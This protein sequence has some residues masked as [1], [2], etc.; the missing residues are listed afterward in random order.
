MLPSA[1]FSLT[2]L[3][4]LMGQVTQ[5]TWAATVAVPLAVAP[6]APAAVPLPPVVIDPAAP[7]PNVIS[8]VVRDA[9]APTTLA[10]DAPPAP[11]EPTTAPLPPATA[12]ADG[13]AQSPA[14]AMA[15]GAAQPPA[16]PTSQVADLVRSQPQPAAP[17]GAVIVQAVSPTITSK[18]IV[19]APDEPSQNPVVLV[20]SSTA[21]PAQIITPANAAGTTTPVIVQTPNPNQQPVTVSSDVPL[22]TTPTAPVPL[23]DAAGA[24]LTAPDTPTAAE[25]P[26]A[27]PEAPARVLIPRYAPVKPAAKITG[28]ARGKKSTP[29]PPAPAVAPAEASTG[30]GE[31]IDVTDI[32]QR[33]S[34][35]LAVAGH[36]PPRLPDRKAR[37]Q[38][39]QD[40]TALV[41]E[42]DPHAVLPN[43]SSE[44]LLRAVKANQIARN[45]DTGNDSALKAGVYMRRLIALAPADPE[46]NYWYGTLLA[47]GGGMA[48]GMPYLNKAI[49]AGYNDAYLPLAQAYLSLDKKTDA[50]NTLKTYR[51]VPNVDA[52]RTDDL[53]ARVEAGATSIW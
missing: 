6:A 9:Q 33:L 44:V 8:P 49:K 28:K 11:A 12:T 29:T 25:A 36:Y 45:L 35:L 21:Q 51:N 13:A 43:A 46:V 32:D 48:E 40:A 14:S 23:V 1:R 5:V 53:I 26:L 19:I 7:A 39:E 41:N 38:A 37:M 24:A 3:V 47:E 18:P 17:A 15:D 20:P 2:L 27:Q 4:A 22:R 52:A 10:V 34:A 50:L 30:A 42:L 31:T 16:L